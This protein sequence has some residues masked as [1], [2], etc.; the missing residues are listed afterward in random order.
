MAE[1]RELKTKVATQCIYG[2]G[3]GLALQLQGWEDLVELLVRELKTEVDAQD[4]YLF[5]PLH[6]AANGGHITTIQRLIQ[7]QH[8]VDMRDYLGERSDASSCCCRQTCCF[9]FPSAHHEPAAR[10][11]L[12][13]SC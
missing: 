2:S 11:V 3:L 5:T 1:L 6:A 10:P 7:Y 4:G 9:S 8:D 13:Q 12:P